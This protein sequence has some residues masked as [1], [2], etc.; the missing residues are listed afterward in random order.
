MF[1]KKISLIIL[2]LVF[3]LSISAVVATDV[4]STDDVISGDVDDDLPSDV[5]QNS[6][7]N[8]D[9]EAPVQKENYV[10]DGDDV[11][12]YY[13]QDTSYKASL[14]N[15]NSSVIGESVILNLNGVNYTK[16][17]NSA[18]KVSLS[19]KNLA[20]GTHV[21][22][23][24]Y[25]NLTKTNKIKVLPIITGKDVTTTYK[26]TV[27]Y[28]AKFLKTNGKALANTYVKF[29]LN[30]KTYSKKTNSYGIAKLAVGSKIGS[31]YIYA[32]NPSGYSIK[33]KITVKNSVVSSNLKKHY[34]SSKVFSATFYGKN[35]KLL[36]G[37][38]IKFYT[39][40]TYFYK[41]TNSKGVASIKVISAPGTYKITSINPSTGEK[42]SNTITVLPTLSA[43]SMTVFTGV[44]SK[45]K[46]TLYKGES[47]AKNAKMNVYVDG[48]KKTVTTDSK[49]VAT[50]SFKLAK[51]TYNFK[52]V[53]PFTGYVLNKKV[54][55]KLAS[56]KAT[57]VYAKEGKQG[58]FQAT[59]LKQSGAVAADT[60]MQI[61]L[62][63]KVYK[64]KT[65]SK[66][67]ASV[68]FTKNEGTYNVVCKDLSTGYTLNKKIDVLKNATSY[69]KF[70]VSDDGKTLI[71][72]GRSS[73][74]GEE[75]KYGYTYYK[76]EIL[77][78][79]PICGGHELYWS[80]F[81]TDE[82]KDGGTFPETPSRAAHYEG[83]NNE[84]I[85]ICMHCTGGG[86]YCDADWSIFG[87]NHD[88]SGR[89][90]TIISGP[91]KS[92]KEEAELIKSGS[93]VSK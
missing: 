44:T 55:V 49:G 41:K 7:T 38:T 12:K 59:L 73:A 9:V 24:F 80:I 36:T 51:G 57:D 89:D 16:T 1:N 88:G 74:A 81:W 63:G 34:R 69:S 52:S 3:M 91:V 20:V 4:N 13:K 6:S 40:G 92:S 84:G 29:K 45:F 93:Y 10:L 58:I 27:Y 14:S 60:Y 65:N 39:K 28:S 68:K 72:V 48:K 50:V 26:Y 64:V 37:K 23:V 47:L 22:T 66:G 53:D 77:N 2:T 87:H 67:I 54:T 15:G 11:N 83:G 62:D 76:T 31:Y 21:I 70:G 19:I 75:S 18:G 33:N 86:E 82:G 71:V 43:S 56:I 85:I 61:S 5:L 17:T 46:V 35:G 79:C 42:R 8:D 32:I 25:G 90:L 30:G 78:T